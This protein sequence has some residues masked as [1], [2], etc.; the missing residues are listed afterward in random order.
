MRSDSIQRNMNAKWMGS[1]HAEAHHDPTYAMS[2]SRE[3]RVQAVLGFASITAVTVSESSEKCVCC[4]S[5][6]KAS[7]SKCVGR[8]TSN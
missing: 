8:F 5:G 2:G 1:K 4:V 3:Y 6:L 7:F